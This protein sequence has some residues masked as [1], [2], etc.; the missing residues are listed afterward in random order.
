MNE[1]VLIVKVGT[2]ERPAG[3]D[4]LESMQLAL[5][6]AFNN[7]TSTIVTHHAVDFVRVQ[8]SDLKNVISINDNYPEVIKT[9]KS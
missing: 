8:R 7:N 4:D 5:R 9:I 3:P 2:D 1:E 6:A